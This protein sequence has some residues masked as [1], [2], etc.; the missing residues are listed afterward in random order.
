MKIA[1]FIDAFIRFFLL[2]MM[3][4][5]CFGFISLLQVMR[6]CFKW[7][8]N[9]DCSCNVWQFCN[10]KCVLLSASYWMVDSFNLNFLYLG[11][12]C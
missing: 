7:L 2:F 5:Q 8:K 4:L 3:Y 10:F 1:T 6:E 9:G 12:K 11:T